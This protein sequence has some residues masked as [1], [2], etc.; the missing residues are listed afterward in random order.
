MNSKIDTFI[1]GLIAIVGS[2][3]ISIDPIL[4]LASGIGANPNTKHIFY[5][6][7]F[8]III[9]FI[10]AVFS[11]YLSWNDYRIKKW[12]K[13]CFLLGGFNIIYTCNSFLYT[14]FK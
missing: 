5:F 9:V 8:V 6:A 4:L 1:S 14:G 12:L 10:T 3:L 2:I 13:V 11:T 7:M